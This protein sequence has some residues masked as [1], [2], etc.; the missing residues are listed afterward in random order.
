MGSFQLKKNQFDQ[1]EQ[2]ENN[3]DYQDNCLKILISSHLGQ[4][5]MLLSAQN[6]RNSPD[7]ATMHGWKTPRNT[8]HFHLNN[9]Q[10]KFNE[11]IYSKFG[12]M[13]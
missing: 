4:F 6:S 2:F 10:D 9:F 5:S 7:Y 1:F 13:K 3:I 11:C 12:D 8:C